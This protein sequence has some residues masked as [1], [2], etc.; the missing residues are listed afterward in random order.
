[1]RQGNLTSV[2]GNS[3]RTGILLLAF[4]QISVWTSLFYVF[5]AMLLRWEEFYGWSKAEITGAL[6]LSLLCS[7]VSSPLVGRKIDQ[8]A[9]PWLLAAGAAFGGVCLLLL[10]INL[11]LIHI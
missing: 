4:G 10:T 9:G 6:T 2:D 7:A 1:M 3:K 11:S 8:G 5:P